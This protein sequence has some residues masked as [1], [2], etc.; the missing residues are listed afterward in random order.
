MSFWKDLIMAWEE[1]A[2]FYIHFLPYKITIYFFNLMFVKHFEK[3]I[4]GPLFYN[5][6]D[7]PSLLL[8]Q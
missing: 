6:I 8:K 5:F 4:Y 1:E 2:M 7:H 3:F